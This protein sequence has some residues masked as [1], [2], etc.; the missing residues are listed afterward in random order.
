MHVLP[1]KSWQ[2]YSAIHLHDRA[3]AYITFRNMIVSLLREE[4]AVNL[5]RSYF[6]GFLDIVSLID[7]QQEQEADFVTAEGVLLHMT[8]TWLLPLS[9][10]SSRGTSYPKSSPMVLQH[11]L[12]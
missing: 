4:A 8:T 2:T 1:C 10:D 12:R 9:M 3:Y 6:V 11:F 7:A 5:L